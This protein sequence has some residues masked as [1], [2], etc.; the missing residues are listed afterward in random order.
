MNGSQCNKKCSVTA[1]LANLNHWLY[2]NSCQ[3][4]W[5]ANEWSELIYPVHL[6]FWLRMCTCAPLMCTPGYIIFFVNVN[7]KASLF[8]KY[9]NCWTR[10]RTMYFHILNTKCPQLANSRPKHCSSTIPKVPFTPITMTIKIT[11]QFKHL[12]QLTI[13][14]CLL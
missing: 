4:C 13:T 7:D 10:N 14:F 8:I 3:P 9:L 6:F 2:M 11:I 12:H 1:P 5:Y